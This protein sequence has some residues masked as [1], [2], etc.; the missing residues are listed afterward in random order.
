MTSPNQGSGHHGQWTVLQ[1]VSHPEALLLR[2]NDYENGVPTA[3]D[4]E[5]PFGMLSRGPGLRTTMTT[6][7]VGVTD[8]V[9]REES[10]GGRK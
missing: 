2:E 10:Y 5:L 7:I 1:T 3:E 8:V 6:V 9:E 4:C